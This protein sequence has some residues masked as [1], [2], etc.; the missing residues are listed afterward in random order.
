MF[1]DDDEEAARRA[2]RAAEDHLKCGRDGPEHPKPSHLE[3]KRRERVVAAALRHLL[4]V[5]QERAK[6]RSGPTGV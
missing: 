6:A 5:Q 1:N 2:L 3:L 4:Y